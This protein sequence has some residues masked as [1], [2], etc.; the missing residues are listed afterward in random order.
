MLDQNWR[1]T[2]KRKQDGQDD[3][4]KD[5]G[6]C[7]VDR[8][9]QVV[10]RCVWTRSL[11]E[12]ITW[13]T[14]LSVGG[15]WLWKVVTAVSAGVLF[16]VPLACWE[17]FTVEVVVVMMVVIVVVVLVLVVA[18]LLAVLEGSGFVWGSLSIAPHCLAG[19]WKLKSDGKGSCCHVNELK[20]KWWFCK[21]KHLTQFEAGV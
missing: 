10:W 19:H 15:G 14:F 2:S 9:C 12:T 21:K 1:K 11:K 17:E 16:G 7:W 3:G 8:W 4:D 13:T 5:H 18:L 6:E 20:L